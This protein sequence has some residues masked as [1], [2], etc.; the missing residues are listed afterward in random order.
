MIKLQKIGRCL[1]WL[2]DGH[3]KRAPF[4]CFGLYTGEFFTLKFHS[5]FQINYNFSNETRLSEKQISQTDLLSIP[6]FIRFNSV[7][8]D[9]WIVWIGYVLKKRKC[10]EIQMLLQPI[11]QAIH[12]AKFE[13]RGDVRGRFDRDVADDSILLAHLEKEL[14]KICNACRSYEF[15]ISWPDTSAVTNTITTILQFG[16]IDRCSEVL[17]NLRSQYLLTELPVMSIV[18]WLNRGPNS[19][20]INT[21]GQVMEER[22]LQIKSTH[23]DIPNLLALVNGLKKVTF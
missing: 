22:V 21:N 19:D 18:N 3:F 14:L 12:G 15:D 8:L 1:H 7:K 13:F 10:E 9:Y 4:L 2:I 16:S 20:A 23:N 11:R 6:A 5:K 17:F